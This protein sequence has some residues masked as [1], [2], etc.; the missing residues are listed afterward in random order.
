MYTA[1]AIAVTVVSDE[2]KTYKRECRHRHLT[3]AGAARCALHLEEELR[4]LA[5]EQADRLTITHTVT[6]ADD[7]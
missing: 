2:M 3:E 6:S 1:T 7:R 4:E 5:G